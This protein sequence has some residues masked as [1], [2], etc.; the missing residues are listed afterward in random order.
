MNEAALKERLKAIASKKETTVNKVWKIL[1]L[2]RFLARLSGSS[3]QEKFVFKGG[4][5]LAQYVT[6][7]RETVDI[8]F[9]MTKIKVKKITIEKIFEEIAIINSEDGFLFTLFSVEELNQP[10]MEYTGFRVTP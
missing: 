10:H 4:L 7:N 3:H 1:L 8:D 2:E 9:L 6:I 5:L